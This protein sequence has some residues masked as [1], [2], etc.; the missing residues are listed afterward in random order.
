MTECE[1]KGKQIKV[2]GRTQ[3]ERVNTGAVG[4]LISFFCFKF[5]YT[6]V[7]EDWSTTSKNL[8]VVNNLVYAR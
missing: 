2:C 5:Q 6:D 3:L 8:H 4:I 7:K 1:G